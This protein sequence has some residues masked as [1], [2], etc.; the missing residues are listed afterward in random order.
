MTSYLSAIGEKEEIKHW[1]AW[2]LDKDKKSRTAL[3]SYYQPW[4]KSIAENMLQALEPENLSFDDVLHYATLA[5]LESIDRYDPSREIP[6]KHFARLRIRGAISSEISLT[7]PKPLES[8][9]LS[10]DPLLAL[11]ELVNEMTVEELISSAEEPEPEPL[12][13]DAYA[14]TE[15]HSLNQQVL[16]GLKLLSTQESTVVR[17]H[18]FDGLPLSEIATILSVSR[19]RVSQIHSVALDKIKNR[20]GLLISPDDIF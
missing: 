13:V 4:L 17:Y 6:F 9:K 19:G 10:N 8:A 16:D 3:V 5:L 11:V 14:S 15:M 1:E 20:I 18:Y 7:I 2:L 12:V